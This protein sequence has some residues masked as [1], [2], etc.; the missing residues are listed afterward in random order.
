MDELPDIPDANDIKDTI[1]AELVHWGQD[2]FA[3]E[4]LGGQ[5]SAR[6]QRAIV[7]LRN[8]LQDAIGKLMAPALVELEER[9][10]GD[11]YI[12]EPLIAALRK[13]GDGAYSATKRHEKQR[14]SIHTDERVT[15]DPNDPFDAAL[16]PIVETNRKKRA[17][18]ARDG[19]PFD[20][21]VTSSDLLGLQGFGPVESALFNMTQKLARLKSLRR[22]GR[23]D[24]PQN[25]A[26]SDTYLDLA[27]YGVL[28]FALA[29]S[30]RK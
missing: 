3:H 1:H 29:R 30:L 28:T 8:D 26:V 16:I 2:V 17:D 21:F 10:A 23:M 27:V 20:N 9:R 4:A 15:L 25:E 6:V 18:Y 22:N 24:D 14:V 13:D 11:A 12:N 19:D 7:E 5:M